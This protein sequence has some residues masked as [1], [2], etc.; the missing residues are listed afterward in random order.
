MSDKQRTIPGICVQ[1]EHQR[2]VPPSNFSKVL[3]IYVGGTIGMKKNGL[4][5]Y[6]PV[7]DYLYETL[8]SMPQFHDPEFYQEWLSSKKLN[9]FSNSELDDID[10]RKSSETLHEDFPCL[11]TA[12]SVYGKRIF[13]QI[14]EYDELLDSSNMTI[15]D[16]VKIASDIERYYKSF[17]AFIV[18]HGSDTMVYTASALSFMLENLGKTVILTG[19]QVFHC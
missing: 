9:G 7:K 16:W 5:G 1:K 13:Y 6:E 19:S 3:I 2:E 15:S 12:V 10:E 18:L 14:L 4:N 17:D 11:V 8:K